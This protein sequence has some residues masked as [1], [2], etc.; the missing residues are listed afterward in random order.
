MKRVGMILLVGLFAVG[1][2]GCATTGKQN[3]EVDNLKGQ[4]S[5]LEEQLRAKDS[6]ISDLRDELSRAGQSQI[7]TPEPCV[8]Q[9]AKSIQ[10]ALKNA[11]FYNGPIDGFIG[12]QTRDAIRAFQKAN[13]LKVDGRVGPK[14]WAILKGYLDKKVK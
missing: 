1:L 10:T 5:S 14:T 7:A 13:N 12:K 4:I 6:E 8:K 3:T 11:G 9:S 2:A